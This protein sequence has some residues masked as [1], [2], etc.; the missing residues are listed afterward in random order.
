MTGMNRI[1]QFVLAGSRFACIAC[2][3][4]MPAWKQVGHC[5]VTDRGRTAVIE[6]GVAPAAKGG[7]VFG[8]FMNLRVGKAQRAHHVRDTPLTSRRQP[9]PFRSRGHGA[10]G[11]F[12]PPVLAGQS[13]PTISKEL[14]TEP[15]DPGQFCP[16]GQAL[17]PCNSIED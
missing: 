1:I 7:C 13:R 15:N 3:K 10:F 17:L 12:A 4:T 6:R 16:V 14:P 11:A 8:V 5:V 9:A 2:Y